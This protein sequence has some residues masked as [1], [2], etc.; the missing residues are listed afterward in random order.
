M[1]AEANQIGQC[2][3]VDRLEEIRVPSRHRDAEG[4]SARL[5][6][7]QHLRNGAELRGGEDVDL[8]LLV[9]Q[10]AHLLGEHHDR[11]VI[12]VLIGRHHVAESNVLTP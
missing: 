9:R 11:P 3:G 10:L 2:E 1:S 5:H 8:E 6:G 4:L 12:Q 7:L